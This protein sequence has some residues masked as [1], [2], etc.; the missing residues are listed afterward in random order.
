[1]TYTHACNR[2]PPPDSPASLFCCTGSSRELWDKLQLGISPI[3]KDESA[4]NKANKPLITTAN[5]RTYY[6]GWAGLEVKPLIKLQAGAMRG[7]LAWQTEKSEQMVP[8]T[9][10]SGVR[11][12]IYL[13][14]ESLFIWYFMILFFFFF[15][16]AAAAAAAAAFPPSPLLLFFFF[17]CGHEH[18]ITSME[19]LWSTHWFLCIMMINGDPNTASCFSFFC[20]RGDFF[21]SFHTHRFISKTAPYAPMC[22]IPIRLKCTT[23]SLFFFFLNHTN[24]CGANPDCCCHGNCLSGV[25]A[26]LK[27]KWMRKSEEVG[28]R[29]QRRH[30]HTQTAHYV[31]TY[32]MFHLVLQRVL[33]AV[34]LDSK[35]SDRH[36]LLCANAR[37][38]IWRGWMGISV[39]SAPSRMPRGPRAET[40]SLPFIHCIKWMC[41]V[42]GGVSEI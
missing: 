17:Y 32:F 1:M 31:P 25:M 2:K 24:Y 3:V 34:Y 4:Q 18:D 21:S 5:K 14:E 22:L 35:R 13:Q 39:L 6:N 11:E 20:H 37:K 36:A 38:W 8:T 7:R 27:L 16:A 19:W 23:P 42:Q 41:W 28:D 29:L 40:S 9:E 10:G 33:L 30:T 12:T 15:F 26:L